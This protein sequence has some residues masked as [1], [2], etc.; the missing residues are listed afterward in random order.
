MVCLFTVGFDCL[1][2]DGLCILIYFISLLVASVCGL[3]LCV[4]DL[5]EFCS[6]TWWFNSVGFCGFIEVFPYYDF[7]RVDLVSCFGFAVCA[8]VVCCGLCLILCC[9][10][11]GLVVVII[12][13]F[14]FVVLFVEVCLRV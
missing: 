11:L 4:F 6:F 1:C 12:F 8:V 14:W 13:V 10:R 9:L 5:S 3:F 7:V 2:Y